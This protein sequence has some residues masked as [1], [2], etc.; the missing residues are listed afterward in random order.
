MQ[1]ISTRGIFKKGEEKSFKQVTLEGL[2]EDGGLFVPHKFP[3][4]N[5]KKLDSMKTM[6]YA[7]LS[8]EVISEFTGEDLNKSEI[9]EIAYKAYSNFLGDDAATLLELRKNKFILELFHG[10]T[11]AFKDFALQ[12]LGGVFDKFLYADN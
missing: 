5:K 3:K 12:L 9:L 2:A 10:P 4:F 11:L 8:A 7:E 6:N 1:Y